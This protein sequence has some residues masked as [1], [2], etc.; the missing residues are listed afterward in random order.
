MNIRYHGSLDRKALLQAL[1]AVVLFGTVPVAIKATA[2][3][4]WTVGIIRLAIAVVVF[5][6]LFRLTRAD[7]LLARTRWQVLLANGVAFT[8]HWMTYFLSIKLASVGLASIGVASYGVH[9]MWMSCVL[10]GTRPRAGDLLGL[11]LVLGGVF[12]VA[13]HVAGGGTKLVGFGLGLLSGFFW[14]MLP[15]FNQRAGELSSRVRSFPQYF[16]GLLLFLPFAGET[17]WVWG[18]KDWVLLLYLGI[19]G[20]LVAHTLWVRTSAILPGAATAVIYYLHLPVALG[21]SWLLLGER[22]TAIQGA[23]I[24][25]IAMGSWLGITA[26]RRVGAVT[27]KKVAASAVDI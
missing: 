6:L 5:P 3:G 2:A 7:L 24:F 12:L 26:S 27:E 20:T 19:A 18:M 23:G 17:Q 25:L 22:M 8:L 16:I 10:T 13:P 15:I 4:P 14:A 21:L 9:L 1:C 11:A